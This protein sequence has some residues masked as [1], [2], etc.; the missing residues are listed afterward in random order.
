MSTR[1]MQRLIQDLIDLR[2][3]ISYELHKRWG[4]SVTVWGE[5][6]YPVRMCMSAARMYADRLEDM[7]WGLM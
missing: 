3:F 1:N 5:D 4:N 6:G 7:D 2:V